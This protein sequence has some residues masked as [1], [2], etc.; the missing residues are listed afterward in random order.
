[1]TGS[2]GRICYSYDES[3]GCYTADPKEFS[4]IVKGSAAGSYLLNSSKLSYKDAN[5]ENKTRNFEEESVNVIAV[6]APVEVERSLSKEEMLVNEEFDVYYTIKPGEFSIDPDLTPPEKF[7]VKNIGFSEKFPE[8]LTVVPADGLTISGQNASI[9]IEDIN[10]TYDASDGKYKANPVS[11]AVKLKGTEG[12]YTLG[13]NNSSKIDYTDLD[14]ETKAKSFPELNPRIIKFGMPKLKVLNVVRRGEKV[15]V[16]LA[17]D[18][19][20][21]TDYGQIRLEDGSAVSV[22]GSGGTV[23]NIQSNGS[24]WY[25]VCPSIKRT[26]VFIGQSAILTP[27]RRIK[28]N[29][30]DIQRN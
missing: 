2:F 27:V 16:E 13:D 12:E 19:P 11:F 28:P 22:S 25:K 18:L 24:Y 7:I 14:S 23:Q 15:D 5:G 29:L 6:S 10:Y 17:V 1:M 30:Y 8:G 26:G 4:I 21:H 20:E 9:D 3:S